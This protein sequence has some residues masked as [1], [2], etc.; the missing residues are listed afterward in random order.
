MQTSAGL[1]ERCRRYIDGIR[2]FYLSEPVPDAPTQ[3]PIA[4]VK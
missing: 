3:L 1:T 4:Y 2:S